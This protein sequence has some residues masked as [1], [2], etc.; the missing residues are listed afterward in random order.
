MDV[1]HQLLCTHTIRHLSIQHLLALWPQAAV[2]CGS[3]LHE[4]VAVVH[5]SSDIATVLLSQDLSTLHNQ[6]HLI[7]VVDITVVGIVCVVV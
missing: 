6:A 7:A 4:L 1:L 5:T 2:L 3:A